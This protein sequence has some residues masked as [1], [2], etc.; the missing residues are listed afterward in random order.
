MLGVRPPAKQLELEAA[1]LA[2]CEEAVLRDL[3]RRCGVA[4]PPGYAR[5]DAVNKL[6]S[7]RSN[8]NTENGPQ[9]QNLSAPAAAAAATT[10]AAEAA[11]A[12]GAAVPGVAG[13]R[14]S[15]GGGARAGLR[16]RGGKGS[17]GGVRRNSV[18]ASGSG[19]K[20]KSRGAKRRKSEGSLEVRRR[21][22]A[23]YGM[24]VWRLIAWK[25]LSRFYG[26]P[27]VDLSLL[28][29]FFSRGPVCCSFTTLCS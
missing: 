11:A 28:K 15:G 20:Q 10:A 6:R 19:S 9:R 25:R 12:A 23:A 4:L 13:R 24:G 17:R 22:G 8:S 16:P 21:G 2:L 27:C 1:R 14:G 3:L 5:A 18:S 26:E 7:G 29:P